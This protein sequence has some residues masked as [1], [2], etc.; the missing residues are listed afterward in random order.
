[1]TLRE[2]PAQAWYQS[3]YEKL[4]PAIESQE[5]TTAITFALLEHYLGYTR[6][7]HIFNTPIG[8]SE[9]V[10]AALTSAS[11]RLVTHEPIQYILGVAEFC[12]LSFEVN[13]HV[14]IPRPETEELVSFIQKE[15]VLQEKKNLRIIDLCT[16]SGCIAIS[17]AHHY[18][19]AQVEALDS[20]AEALAVAEKNAK[21]LGVNVSFLKC[22]LLKKLLPK[23][24]WDVVVSNP[25]YVLEKEG[26]KM[27]PRVTEHEPAKALFV[28]DKT[29]LL[30]YNRIA[31]IVP[32]HLAPLGKVY[33]EINEAFGKEV[34][35][36][37]AKAG[38]EN[39]KVHQDIHGKDRWVVAQKGEKSSKATKK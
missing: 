24:K 7:K 30:F 20:S 23:Q 2:Q 36:L 18:K 14:L 34:A 21:K 5:E 11:D 26:K 39:V 32:K 16:G 4:L 19:D 9:E 6:I 12:G 28:P 15:K 38:L 31:K 25:P 22:D 37:F 29:P 3:F 10:V 27:H 1:M 13:A 8:A 35:A 33:V 17:L